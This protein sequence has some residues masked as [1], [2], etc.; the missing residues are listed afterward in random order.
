MTELSLKI[1]EY[2][3]PIISLSLI[4]SFGLF[5][6]FIYFPYDIPIYTDGF[7]YFVYSVSYVNYRH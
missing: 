4:I 3:K 5:L 7:F 1:V 2:K 6:R